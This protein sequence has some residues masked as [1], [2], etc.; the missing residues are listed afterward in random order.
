MSESLKERWIHYNEGYPKIPSRALISDTMRHIFHLES[1]LGA[2]IAAIEF[3]V[4]P[5]RDG[6]DVEDRLAI[7]MQCARAARAALHPQ[8][9]RQP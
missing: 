2:L 1:E 7:L 3:E 9:D 5:I 8:V 4:P 6:V